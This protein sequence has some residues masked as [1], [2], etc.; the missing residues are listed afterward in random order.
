[1]NTEL[2]KELGLTKAAEKLDKGRALKSKLAIAYEHYRF[3]E[4]HIVTRF[5]EQ[6]HDKTKKIQEVCRQ[7]KNKHNVERCSWCRGTGAEHYTHDKLSFILLEDYEE[8]PP[9]D[10]LLDLKKA[11]D[12]NC[13]DSFEVAKVETVE[14][15]PDPIIFGRINN[16]VDR[17]FITQWDD[18]VKIED[19][20]K[21]NEG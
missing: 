19:I 17:F 5:Q 15:R 6:I 10:C 14:V 3:V 16:C 13:F 11:K 4:P 20:L 1:M 9:P 2:L 7:C 12:M 18:D 21:E 8:V